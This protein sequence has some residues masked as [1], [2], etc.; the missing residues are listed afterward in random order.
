[1]LCFL[2]V[3]ITV[4]CLGDYRLN[5]I[6]PEN[7]LAEQKFLDGYTAF[8]WSD[9]ARFFDCGAVSDNCA[10]ARFLSFFF[11]YA[12]TFFRLWLVQYLPPHPSLSLTWF[13]S[14]ASLY[15]FYCTLIGLT[16]DRVAA[17]LGTGL[18][19]VSAGFLSPMLML[20]NPAK[21]LAGFF[22]NLCLWLA[23]KIWRSG[24]HSAI[25]GYA[26]TLY[27]ALFLAYCSDETAWFLCGA[28]PVLF[29]YLLRRRHWP[30]LACIIA[31]FALFLA[32]TTWIAPVATRY[33]YNYAHF[34]MWSWAFN[35]GPDAEPG[36]P[37][38]LERFNLEILLSEALNMVESEF[39]WWRAGPSIAAVSLLLPFCGM[40]VAVAFARGR[41][42]R[43]FIHTSLLLLLY[44]GFQCVLLLRH[45]VGSGTYYYS[46]LFA[47]FALLL[48]GIAI[49][50]VRDR[51]AARNIAF[52]ATLYLGYVS[53][54]WCLATDREWIAYHDRIFA[55]VVG[56]RYGPLI[57]GEPLTGAKVVQYWRMVRE[58][59][60]VEH[61]G[62]SF[63]PKDVWLFDLMRGWHRRYL[64]R[65]PPEARPAALD[66]NS[67]DP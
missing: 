14:F 25:S 15:L 57:P 27:I 10:R 44:V 35:V 17:F 30:L 28:I 62:L 24:K 18:L 23:T 64:S 4:S 7:W 55:S 2:A 46:N 22:V 50:C 48:V 38:L 19:A 60:D 21:A 42:R 54:T 37:P 58:G 49:A 65:L 51:P 66:L 1:M 26:I 43:L 41:M 13:L 53:F 47:N 33:F 52:L 6:H 61:S 32:F 39:A 12:D 5:W 45:Y 20:F 67:R 31:T 63:A 9:F 3:A 36:Q 29:P 11:S 16:R 40:I 59:A 34:D 8:H 56:N